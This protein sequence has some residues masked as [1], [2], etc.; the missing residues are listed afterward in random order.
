MFRKGHPNYDGIEKGWF[1]KGNKPYNIGKKFSKESIEKMRLAK[2]GKKQSQETKD[3]RSKSLIGHI[4]YWKGKTG[5]DSFSWKGGISNWKYT[6]DW[7]I[8]LRQS[9]RERDNYTCQLCK[10]KQGDIA[11]SV[12]HIDYNKENCNP[13]NLI[14]LCVR[15]HLKTNHNRDYWENYFKKI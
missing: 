1:K 8:S 12:H 2:L 13:N 4:G 11:L 7:T 5:K 9:I 15:C 14:S 6:I 10:E 3:K